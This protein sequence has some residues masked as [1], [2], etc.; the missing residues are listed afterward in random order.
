[1]GKTDKPPQPSSSDST[2]QPS[3]YP[4]QPDIGVVGFSTDTSPPAPPDPH[5]QAPHLTSPPQSPYPTAFTHCQPLLLPP[6]SPDQ[7]FSYPTVSTEPTR[8]P[9]PSGFDCGRQTV[10]FGEPT[11]S[12]TLIDLD[13]ND[14]KRLTLFRCL[15]LVLLCA[16]ANYLLLVMF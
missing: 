1:M 3:P 4:T 15:H 11:P 13:G 10:N 12:A 5:Y 14:A 7:S 6:N 9:V 2:Y 8:K 16:G